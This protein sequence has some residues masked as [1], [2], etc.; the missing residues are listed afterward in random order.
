MANRCPVCGKDTGSKKFCPFCGAPMPV[1]PSPV[2]PPPVIQQGAVPVPTIQPVKKNRTALLV[3]LAVVAVLV[4]AGAVV[5]SVLLSGG[6]A[7]LKIAAPADGSTV[8]GG[9]VKVK[10]E[11]SGTAAISRVDIFL[12]KE[13][14]STIDSS[15]YEAE[16]AGVTAGIH[17]LEAVA[18]DG[19]G[20]RLASATSTFE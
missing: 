12:D 1:P 17:D 11:V 19:G 15:P 16:L 14:R 6:G 20:A 4:V 7:S 13:K 18:F 8:S 3:T 5:A 2:L 10:V 9:S